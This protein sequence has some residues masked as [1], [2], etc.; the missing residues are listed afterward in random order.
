MA[1][2]QMYEEISFFLCVILANDIVSYK[3][4]KYYQYSMCFYN[5]G[6]IQVIQ[7]GKCDQPTQF[8]K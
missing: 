5:F 1:P 3:I 8:L 7:G 4:L 6:G 2:H